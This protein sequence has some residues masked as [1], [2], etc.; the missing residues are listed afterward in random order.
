MTTCYF[1]QA[2]LDS[3]ITISAELLRHDEIVAFPTETVYGLGARIF[4]EAAIRKVYSAKGR[5]SDNPLIAHIATIEQAGEIAIEIPDEFYLLAEHFF[6]GPL[7]IVLNRHPDVPAIVSAGLDS[8][9]VRMPQHPIALALIKAV[10][11]P[12]VAPSA[13][14]SGKPSPTTAQHVLDDLGGKI[15]AIIDGGKCVVGIESTVLNICTS[16]PTILRPGAVTREQIETVLSRKIDIQSTASPNIPIA[17]GMKY[18]HY[19]P[20]ATIRIVSTWDE[21]QQITNNATLSNILIL[22]N[23][24]PDFQINAILH[25]LLAESLYA[26]FRRADA[27]NFTEIVILCDN[28][29]IQ[30]S[31]LM[32][33]I[34]KAAS[35]S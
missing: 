7:T 19:A 29:I 34:T 32:N 5:P 31:A 18:R 27:D 11:Q 21:I 26:E 4:S 1:A 9:A 23:S 25:P 10:G 22:A 20:S 24:I 17:P 8:I 3:A 15:A 6:P 33:R 12:L 13:N 35:K 14:L 2:E 16:I 30:D 28:T